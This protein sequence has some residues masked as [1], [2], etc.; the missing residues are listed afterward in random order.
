MRFNNNNTQKIFYD[1]TLF[2]LFTLPFVITFFLRN[3]EDTKSV[4]S[5]AM[6]ITR[7]TRIQ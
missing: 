7:P 4:R 3:I 1:T 5:N 2:T 6:V